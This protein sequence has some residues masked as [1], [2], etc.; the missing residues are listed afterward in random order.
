M[1]AYQRCR[2]RYL[3]PPDRIDEEKERVA[4]INYDRYWEKRTDEMLENWHK[5]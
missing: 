2:E 5:T 1:N 4:Q 3:D